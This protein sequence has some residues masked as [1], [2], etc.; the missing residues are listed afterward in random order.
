MIVDLN[1]FS[2]YAYSFFPTASM[3]QTFLTMNN[4]KT[5]LKKGNLKK[6]KKT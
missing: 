2:A 4:V 6:K 5:R 3:K 1:T